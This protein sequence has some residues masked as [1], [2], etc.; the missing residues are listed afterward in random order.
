MLGRFDQPG[1][2]TTA[3]EI[4]RNFG[5]WQDRAMQGPILVTHHGRPRLVIL[6]AE[7]FSSLA[8]GAAGGGGPEP[9]AATQPVES[10]RAN[11]IANM[12]EGFV[13]FDSDLRV[14]YLNSVA[15]A[16]A[17]RDPKELIGKAVDSPEFG[18]QGTVLA[19][20]LRR[21]LRTGEACQFESK[22][23]FNPHRYF[24]SKAFPFQGGVGVTFSQLTELIDLRRDREVSQAREQ[25]IDAL[26]VVSQLNVNAMGF[27]ED[28]NAAFCGLLGF[29]EAQIRGA[30]LVDFV[31]PPQRHDFSQAMN[32]VMQGKSDGYAGVVQFL[33]RDQGYISLRL[34]AARQ[35][36]NEVCIGL[37]VACVPV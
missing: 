3:A 19:A 24:E 12:F 7:E 2:K 34:S 16:S 27:V 23:F 17:G 10:G 6:S 15:S 21:V 20:R 8:E 37:A 26:G 29:S 4:S 13:L 5:H 36:H 25:A 33:V 22:G 14:R 31:A 32:L 28:T 9:V 18:E 1:A 35:C 30:R 11:F